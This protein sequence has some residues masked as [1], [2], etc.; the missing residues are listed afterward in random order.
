MSLLNDHSTK[1]LERLA[2]ELPENMHLCMLVFT[3]HA[4]GS[5]CSSE[6]FTS[7]GTDPEGIKECAARMVETVKHGTLI[8]HEGGP[9]EQH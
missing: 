7:F 1:L 3:T 8:E 6:V 5:M 2:L 4:D 9:H